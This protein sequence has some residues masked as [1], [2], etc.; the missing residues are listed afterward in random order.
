M[1]VVKKLP[2]R[3]K[4]IRQNQRMRLRYTHHNSRSAARVG[5]RS[6]VI[7]ATHKWPPKITTLCGNNNILYR[8]NYG[9]ANKHTKQC[10][11][12]TEGMVRQKFVPEKCKAMIM[13]G[14]ST[15][16]GPAIQALRLSNNFIKWTNSERLLGV[17]FD[18][19]LSWSDHAPS[20]A[21]RRLLHLTVWGLC[22]KTHINN[23]E[24]V[25][26]RAEGIVYG[27]GLPWET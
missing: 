9:F 25:H 1:A 24:K 20:N 10:S 15:F 3:K 2:H 23:Q 27:H 12:W 5:P 18:N 21:I 7:L 17:Q 4:T 6:H 13:Q 22:N 16:T 11:R 14:K 8:I 26:A 19:K